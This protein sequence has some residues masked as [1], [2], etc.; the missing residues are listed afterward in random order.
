MFMDGV[1][2]VVFSATTVARGNSGVA[3]MSS[4]NF[5]GDAAADSSGKWRLAAA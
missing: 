4:C 2:A 5:I 3:A 1:L